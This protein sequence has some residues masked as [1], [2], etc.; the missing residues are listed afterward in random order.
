VGVGS[1]ALSP[2]EYFHARMF[3]RNCSGG[4]ALAENSGAWLG[5]ALWA[6]DP[7]QVESWAWISEMKNTQSCLF[8][9]GRESFSF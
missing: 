9:F 4:A 7:L 6:L 8:L 5:A 2:R 3:R 1:A